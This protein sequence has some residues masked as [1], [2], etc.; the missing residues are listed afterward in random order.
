MAPCPRWTAALLSRGTS[1]LTAALGSAPVAAVCVESVLVSV[2][3]ITYCG[4]IGFRAGILL[5]GGQ[6]VFV[7]G[8]TSYKQNKFAGLEGLCV[9]LAA[10]RSTQLAKGCIH[11]V[12]LFLTSPSL[13]LS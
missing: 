12:S 4:F 9:Q 1:I 7:A 10:L 2:L 11:L 5:T 8:F 3:F 13:P 6:Y